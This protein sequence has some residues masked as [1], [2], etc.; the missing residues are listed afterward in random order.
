MRLPDYKHV[1][2]I[3]S[4]PTVCAIH[5]GQGFKALYTVPCANNPRLLR[6]MRWT[7]SKLSGDPKFLVGRKVYFVESDSPG[8]VPLLWSHSRTIEFVA[9]AYSAAGLPRG[10]LPSIFASRGQVCTATAQNTAL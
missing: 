7:V 4:R 2:H 9:E 10:K 5:H 1:K 3:K 6:L 8:A